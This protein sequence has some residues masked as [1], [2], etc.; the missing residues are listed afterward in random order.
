MYMLTNDLVL[1]VFSL[2]IIMIKVILSQL[3]KTKLKKKEKLEFQVSSF[4]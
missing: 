3:L 1:D 4:Y 2:E